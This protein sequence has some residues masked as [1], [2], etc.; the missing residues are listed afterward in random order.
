MTTSQASKAAQQA[1]NSGTRPA[2][3]VG[4]GPLSPADVL[5]VAR[6]GAPVKLADEAISAVRRGREIVDALANDQEPHYGVSTGFGAL[7]TRHIAPQL[8]A[9]L[10]ASL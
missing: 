7:A 3:I 9:Q 2:V 8:R 4:T 10:Q 6:G 5:A 1:V